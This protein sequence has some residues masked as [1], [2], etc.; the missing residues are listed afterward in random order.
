M[1]FYLFFLLIQIARLDFL[2]CI[3]F[4]GQL[5]TSLSKRTARHC[6]DPLADRLNMQPPECIM[7]HFGQCLFSPVCFPF[8]F[9]FENALPLRSQDI[10]HTAKC[11]FA[12]LP[13]K[14][15][16]QLTD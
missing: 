2:F 3:C 8:H 1:D 12:L 6:K 16:E 4:R 7:T 11:P 15:T 9:S 10:E 5:G 13:L 14:I